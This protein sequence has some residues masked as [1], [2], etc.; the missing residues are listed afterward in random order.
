MFCR[1]GKNR[2]YAANSKH[3]E[4]TGMPQHFYLRF[5][6]TKRPVC[7]GVQEF[8]AYFRTAIP[9][10]RDKTEIDRPDTGFTL[11]R[12]AVLL[13]NN[14]LCSAG[15]DFPRTSEKHGITECS[16]MKTAMNSAGKQPLKSKN[17]LSAVPT[18]QAGRTVARP[19]HN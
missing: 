15:S 1:R 2:K 3:A 9:E 8:A 10:V 5:L 14:A 6:Y 7:S 17:R 16:G 19:H 11:P 12:P 4:H 18:D 13:A